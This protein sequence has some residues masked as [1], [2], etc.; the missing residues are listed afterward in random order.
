MHQEG[1][2][3]HLSFEPERTTVAAFNPHDYIKTADDGFAHCTNPMAD[4]GLSAITV[5]TRL[6]GEML[7]NFEDS[8]KRMVLAKIFSPKFGE[9]I[10]TATRM[11]HQAA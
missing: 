3:N 7:K 10:L 8:V 2:Y 11:T 6:R 5:N 9:V 4:G 1:Y